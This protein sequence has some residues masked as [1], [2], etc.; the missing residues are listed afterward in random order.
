MK[1]QD[2]ANAHFPPETHATTIADAFLA[3]A[4]ADRSRAAVPLVLKDA[5]GDDKKLR[6]DG[7]TPPAVVTTQA[8]RHHRQARC[9][10][11]IISAAIAEPIVS[12]TEMMA[13]WTLPHMQGVR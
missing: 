1:L 5:D 8:A 9:A 10:P 12:A 11:K 6:K 7:K 13:S 3:V 4:E 2:I